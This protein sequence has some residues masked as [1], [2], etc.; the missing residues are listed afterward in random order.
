MAANRKPG[1]DWEAVERDYRA[2]QISLRAI[3]AKHGVSDTAIRKRAKAE[4]WKRVLG[5]KVREAVREELVRADGSQEGSQAERV[6]TDREIVEESAKVGVEIVRQHRG[7]LARLTRI[8]GGLADELEAMSVHRHEIE[9]LI[10]AETEGEKDPK[11]RAAL[12]KVVSLHDRSQTAR[13]LSQTLKNLIPLER[14]AFNLD[15]QPEDLTETPLA[16]LLRE[17]NG[18]A[19]RPRED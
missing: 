5:A 14:Q 8:A 16:R 7:H 17:L 1:T 18:T 10:E 12:M 11:R 13:E 3:G 9:A 2:D 6:R 4:G 19:I 15:E